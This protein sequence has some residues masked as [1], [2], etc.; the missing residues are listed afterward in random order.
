ML[1]ER[2]ERQSE[3]NNKYK[4]CSGILQ[5][6]IYEAHSQQRKMTELKNKLSQRTSQHLRYTE[7]RKGKRVR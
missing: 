6:S 7:N 3:I 2:L 4:I 1:R 5:K